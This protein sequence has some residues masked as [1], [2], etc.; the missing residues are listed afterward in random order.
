MRSRIHTRIDTNSEIDG[1]PQPPRQRINQSELSLRLTVKAVD[2][3]AQRVFH[4]ASRFP[5]SGKYNLLRIPACLQNAKQFTRR[6]NIE[7]TPRLRQQRKDSQRRIRFHTIP[8]HMGKLA[9]AFVV[10][11]IV[12]KNDLAR[13]NILE[14]TRGFG[15]V[16]QWYVFAI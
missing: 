7:S 15:D 2:P 12:I 8:N 5:D 6:D 1:N 3:L 10:S 13:I 16:G 4:L 11:A 14:R 9:Q